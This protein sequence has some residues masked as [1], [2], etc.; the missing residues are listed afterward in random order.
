MVLLMINE[1][2][3]CLEERIVDDPRD[4]DFGMVMGTGFAPFRGG[5]SRHADRIG[6]AKVTEDLERLT[7]TREQP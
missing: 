5:P 1:A 3:R 6:I 7:R 4:V 2:S